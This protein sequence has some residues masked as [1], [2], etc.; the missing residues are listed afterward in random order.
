MSLSRIVAY[1]IVDERNASGVAEAFLSTIDSFVINSI[2]VFD[3][4]VSSFPSAG[5][6]NADEIR[7]EMASDS[8][9]TVLPEISPPADSSS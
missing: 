1:V 5:V 7:R 3:S 4:D 6:P 9:A 8:S 2:P